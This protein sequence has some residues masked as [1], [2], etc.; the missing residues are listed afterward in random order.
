M[1]CLLGV[2]AA[3]VVYWRTV[4]FGISLAKTSKLPR[5]ELQVDPPQVEVPSTPKAEF[6]PEVRRKIE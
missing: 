6:G 2:F 1:G 5:Y 3:L 4:W